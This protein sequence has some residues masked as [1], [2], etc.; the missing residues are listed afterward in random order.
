MRVLKKQLKHNLALFLFSS[1]LSAIPAM[2]ATDLEA[3]ESFARALAKSH[4]KETDHAAHENHTDKSLE[5]HGVF[6]G[7]LPCN[8]CNGIKT[9]LSLKQNNNYLLV[10]QYAKESSREFYEKGK[11]SWNDENHTVVLTPRKG[12]TSTRR[13]HIE[14]EGTLIQLN[15][16]GTRKTDEAGRYVLQRSDT[17]KS[18]E[19]HIH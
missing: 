13:Y 19:I 5:F 3:Q 17:V 9:T 6:Y 11:Y 4:Q 12:G 15:D 14:N 16:D 2:A 10:T 18:R 1:L 7:F 8:D